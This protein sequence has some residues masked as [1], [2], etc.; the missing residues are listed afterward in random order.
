MADI[1]AEIK[2]TVISNFQIDT[3][4]SSVVTGSYTYAP[5]TIL[6]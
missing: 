2:M 3:P 4:K 6:G 1:N 5:I